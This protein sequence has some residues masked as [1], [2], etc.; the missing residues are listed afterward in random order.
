M[1]QN[2]QRRNLRA[3]ILR[4]RLDHAEHIGHR[5]VG[6]VVLDDQCAVFYGIA[7]R[8]GVIERCIE[9]DD[10]EWFGGR[11]IG[12]FTSKD[13]LRNGGSIVAVGLVRRI[14]IGDGRR[15]AVGVARGSAARLVRRIGHGLHVA[16]LTRRRVIRRIM[17]V[18]AS[19][20]GCI[21]IGVLGR[22][23]FKIDL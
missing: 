20:P 6:P 17:R 2:R 4:G 7:E 16:V 5:R 21:G 11:R 9:Q 12:R 23:R 19:V 8:V 13:T 1:R 10:V 15:I 3:A 18:A 22:C 14:G